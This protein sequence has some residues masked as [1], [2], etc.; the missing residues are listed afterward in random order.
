MHKADN[1]TP[2]VAIVGKPNVGK[3]SVFNRLIGKRKAIISGEPGV[4]RDINYESL[5][6]G[7]FE[8]KLA[9]SAGYTRSRE[10]IHAWTMALNERLIE[11]A[12][13]LLLVC[14]VNSLDF[15]DFQIA[16]IIRRTGKPSIVLVNKVDND[17]KMNGL[18]DFFELGFE[19]LLPF[20]ASHGKNID[21]LRHTISETLRDMGIDK[22]EKTYSS[23]STGIHV[24]II[25]K[26]NVGKSSL[27][28]IL[29][30]SERSLVTPHPGTTRDTVDECISYHGQSITFVDTAGIR[31]RTKVRENIE[32]YSIVRAENAV[33]NTHIALLVID[34]EEG[35]THQE[36]RIAHLVVKEK[37]G[38]IVALNKWDLIRGKGIP[39]PRYIKELF[40]SFPH[41]AFAEVVP[42]S[43]K[44][45]YNKVQL[46]EKIFQVYNSLNRKIKTSEL[47]YLLQKLSLH[48]AR[49]KYGVQKS[50]SP[51]V[52][53]LFLGGTVKNVE[54]FRK[55]VLNSIRNNFYFAGVPI[56]VHLR[57]G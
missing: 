36:K 19:N 45:G 23:D 3:S 9:D 51:P 40:I 21:I 28:N 13:L 42:V 48:R 20:S 37:K 11:Q 33:K 16:E 5:H 54:N 44:T 55:Y 52:F 56:E 41:I 18:Y 49:I 25:G 17:T 1:H 26:P 29:V 12:S 57:K 50:T 15:E 8:V 2:V 47:N 6:I 4:T 38:L 22:R 43:A 31:K 24:A 10:D 27:L 7:D 34:A 53:E 32:F 39:A 14:E 35:I 30:N 46:L